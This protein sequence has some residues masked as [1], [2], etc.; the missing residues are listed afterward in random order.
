MRKKIAVVLF[1][2]LTLG[3]LAGCG[4]GAQG[5][6]EPAG[7]ASASTAAESTVSDST[8][9]AGASSAS[10][11]SADTTAGF[12]LSS[13]K[14]L[15]DAFALQGKDEDTEQRAFYEDK[16]IYVFTVDGV[17]YRVIADL[18]ADISEKLF[19]LE[20]DENYEKNEM[21]LVSDLEVATAENLN[22]QILPQEELDAL[23]GKTGQEL[24]DE[25]WRSGSF[26]N[27]ENLEVWLEYGPFS[28][29]FHFDGKVAPE[30]AEDFDVYEG[31][32]DMKVLDA[33]FEGLGDATYME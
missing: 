10:A 7:A 29:T 30:D 31:L 19:A 23:V 18:P 15:G 8:A 9:Q 16:Y 28:Y 11:A 33:A 32:A 12:D 21:D 26:Y 4:S 22:E 24:F 5:N 27:T 14:T 17:P 6:K 3:L 2:V 13:L 1:A 25:G 20:Y